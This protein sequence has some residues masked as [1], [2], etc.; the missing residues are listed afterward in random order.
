[1][2]NPGRLESCPSPAQM[3]VVGK[4]HYGRK[5]VP[6]GGGGGRAGAR[7][8]FDTLLLWR[9]RVKVD[10]AGRARIEVPLNDS[11]TSFRLVAVANAGDQYF[12]TGHASIRTTQELMLHSGLAPLVR[13]GDRYTATFTLRNAS[14]RPMTVRASA[15]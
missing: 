7:E 4:R 2:T 13:A 3:Q 12:G 8:L 9:G 6:A 10:A 11:L 1:L 14:K 5:A 15:T